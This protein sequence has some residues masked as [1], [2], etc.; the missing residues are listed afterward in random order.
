[1]RMYLK[2]L[3]ALL[4]GLVLAFST[5]CGN[6]NAPVKPVSIETTPTGEEPPPGKEA[7]LPEGGP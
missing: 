4:F 7:T 6:N 5:G 3:T 2:G 1:M